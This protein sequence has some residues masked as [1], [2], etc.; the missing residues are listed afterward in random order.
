MPARA[1]A[2]EGA[3]GDRLD[4]FR[5]GARAFIPV[6]QSRPEKF[7]SPRTRRGDLGENAG[8]FAGSDHIAPAPFLLPAGLVDV[9]AGF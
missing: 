7:R 6:D 8:S 4:H 9:A 2:L 3:G 1:A 5:P